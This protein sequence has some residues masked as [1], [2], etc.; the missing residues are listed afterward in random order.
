VSTATTGSFVLS[1][2]ALLELIGSENYSGRPV[3]PLVIAC[4]ML[5]AAADELRVLRCCLASEQLDNGDLDLVLYR[6][7][8]R[9]DAAANIAWDAQRQEIGEGAAT[10]SGGS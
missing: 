10:E 9:M 8:E 4:S 7:C 5:D 1:G 3:S 6:L 2:A